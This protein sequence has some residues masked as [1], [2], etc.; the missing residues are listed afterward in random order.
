MDM[1]LKRRK[2]KIENER[3]REGVPEQEREEG[4]E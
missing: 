2:E 1:K 4:G 3:K